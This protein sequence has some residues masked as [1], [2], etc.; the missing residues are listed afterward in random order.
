MESWG[1]RV[2]RKVRWSLAQRGWW[3]TLRAGS[4]RLWAQVGRLWR[5]EQEEEVVRHPFDERYGVETSGLIGGGELVSGHE[6]DV[7][8][9]AYYGIAPSVLRRSLVLWAASEGTGEVERYTFVDVGCGKGRAVMIA[10]E[11]PFLEA[12]G[13]ELNPELARVAAKN[14]AVWDRAGRARCG[15][16]VACQDAAAMELPDGPCLLYLYNPFEETVLRKVLA[17]LDSE[18]KRTGQR[19]DVLY[20]NPQSEGLF[21][22]LA[23]FHEMWRE[24][25]ALSEEDRAADCVS[26]VEDVC[27]AFRREGRGQGR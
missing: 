25:I 4:G 26:T 9:T 27:V 2:W 7:F 18:A 24:V 12:R 15:M 13:V 14:F 5:R 16:R 3:G 23:G 1:R 6:H 21:M 8:A 11:M 17:R 22:E 20:Q 10:A 19:V